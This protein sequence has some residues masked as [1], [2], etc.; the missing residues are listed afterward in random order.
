MRW[1]MSKEKLPKISYSEVTILEDCVYRHKLQ[2]IDQI[3]GSGDNEFSVFG[4]AIHDN[5]E[6]QML[7]E[8]LPQKEKDMFNEKHD[9]DDMFVERFRDGLKQMRADGKSIDKKLCLDMKQQGLNLLPDILPALKEIPE[10]KG[11]KLIETEEKLYEKI[12]D[13]KTDYWFKGYIDLVLKVGDKYYIID[14]KTTTWGWDARTKSSPRKTYQLTLYKHFWCQKHDVDP[15]NVETYF[16]LL[17]R[18][19]KKDRVEI[20]RVTSGPKKRANAIAWVEKMMKRIPIKLKIKNRSN[21]RWCPYY[22]R[23]CK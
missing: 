9:W 16:A 7:V 12:K 22:K 17:K 19:A 14:W 8:A 18:T 10:F 15:K 21:C 4:T 3:P 6:K 11:Y 23:Q 13:F 1:R 2:Y 20:F 5:A